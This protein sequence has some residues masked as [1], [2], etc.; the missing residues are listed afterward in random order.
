MNDV[1]TKKVKKFSWHMAPG[2]TRRR[3][4]RS[5]RLPGSRNLVVG[6]KGGLVRAWLGAQASK[7]RRG[8]GSA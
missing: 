1:A 3:V 7:L 4:R 2:T 8:S 5:E 6:P